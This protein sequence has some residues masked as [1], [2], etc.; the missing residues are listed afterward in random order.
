MAASDPVVLSWEE[1]KASRTAKRA[2]LAAYG[3]DR[4]SRR[5]AAIGSQ[6]KRLRK[7]FD[8]KRAPDF[9]DGPSN[10]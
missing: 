7:A 1:W 3:L 5:T 10:G 2:A 8:G 4:P 6:E 9:A